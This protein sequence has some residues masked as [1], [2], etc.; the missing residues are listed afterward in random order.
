MSLQSGLPTKTERAVTTFVGPFLQVRLFMIVQTLPVIEF[1][2][3]LLAYMR[4]ITGVDIYMVAQICKILC[5]I[6]AVVTAMN[7]ASTASTSNSSFMCKSVA[8]RTPFDLQKENI[9]TLHS[10]KMEYQI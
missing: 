5:L 1:S 7:F 10:I 2:T 3:T 4:L 9:I 6:R 8:K